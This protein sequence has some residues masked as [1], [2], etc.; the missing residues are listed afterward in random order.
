METFELSLV[1]FSLISGFTN[2]HIYWIWMED[3]VKIKF[4]L[5]NLRVVL[6]SNRFRVVQL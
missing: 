1:F 5:L 2:Q 3:E 6:R 4:V